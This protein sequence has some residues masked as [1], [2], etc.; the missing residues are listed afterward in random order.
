MSVLVQLTDKQIGF[1]VVY[2]GCAVESGSAENIKAY[3][4]IA[5]CLFLRLMIAA[6]IIAYIAAETFRFNELAVTLCDR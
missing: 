1:L 5:K 6:D 3:H 2:L 4:I